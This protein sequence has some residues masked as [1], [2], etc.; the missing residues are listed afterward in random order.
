MA[1]WQGNVLGCRKPFEAWSSNQARRHGLRKP[2]DARAPDYEL[3]RDLF[4]VE[5]CYDGEM[6]RGDDDNARGPTL[7]GGDGGCP[8]DVDL[9]HLRVLANLM[10]PPARQYFWREHCG[11]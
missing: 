10:T 11:L 6:P 9:H 1:S 8:R 5:T 7:I 4:A 2:F 3:R